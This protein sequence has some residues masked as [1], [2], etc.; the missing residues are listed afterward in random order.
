MRRTCHGSLF[1]S[2]LLGC[3]YTSA[4]SAAGLQEDFAIVPEGVLRNLAKKIVMP[5]YPEASR[6]R[7]VKGRAVAQVDVDKGGNLTDVKI[8]EAPDADIEQAVLQAIQQ[9]KFGSA[10]AGEERKPVRLRG[11]LTFYFV[12]SGSQARVENP[13]KFQ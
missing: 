2:L 4:V 11:K 9:W 3:L 12:L 10:T 1:I 13:R 8:I 6:K 7:G 5:K